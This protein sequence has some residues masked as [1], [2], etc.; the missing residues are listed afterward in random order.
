MLDNIKFAMSD[1]KGRQLPM[2]FTALGLLANLYDSKLITRDNAYDVCN[3]IAHAEPR[4]KY[5]AG[6][7]IIIALPY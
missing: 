7:F 2:H 6:D 3:W 5:N 1:S 4:Q